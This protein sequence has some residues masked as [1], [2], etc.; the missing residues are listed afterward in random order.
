MLSIWKPEKAGRNESP[1]RKSIPTDGYINGTLSFA[2]FIT[3]RRDLLFKTRRM[4]NT[5]TATAA[6]NTTI[7]II[8]ILTTESRAMEITPSI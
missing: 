8:I 1:S 7:I 2:R 5:V 4:R 3:R 6:R